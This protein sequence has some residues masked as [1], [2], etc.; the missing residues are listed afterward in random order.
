LIRICHVITDLNAGGAERMLVN[1]VTRLD[2]SRFDN[3]V[4]SLIEPGLMA[5]E[6]T[7]AGIPVMNL[8]MRRGRPSLSGMIALMRR[9]R[10]SRPAILQSW[11]YHADLAAALASWSIPDTSLVWNLRCSDLPNQSGTR[12]LDRIVR[13]L[14]WMSTRPQAVV[15]NSEKGKA[16]H[17]E[18]G[19]RPRRWA[20]IPNGVDT[21]RFRPSPEMR[22]EMRKKIGIAAGAPVIGWVARLHP[23]KDF[24][25]FL[26]AANLFSKVRQDA[27]FIL[28]GEGFDR[29]NGQ[30]LQMI[31]ELGLENH[32]SLLGVRA[33]MENIYPACDV[34]A[35][36]SA[37]GEG[38]PN[39]LIEAM[40]CGVPCV[41]TDVGDS[42]AIVADTGIIVPPRDP[43]ALMRGWNAVTAASRTEP[44]GDRARK[45]AVDQYSIDR[46]CL[47]YET[48]Y[49]ELFRRKQSADHGR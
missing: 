9:L 10:R 8:D 34:F 13:A 35:L 19:Y 2:R 11:L 18:F 37:Y 3:E 16:F 38:F 4:I 40:A 21:A 20:L 28:C 17:S 31:A 36:S 44:F 5:G 41:A 43:D 45:R 33:D 24:P 30:V 42:R 7:A 25:T 29:R 46:V 23:M 26:Q 15:V 49:Y 27:H 1:L 48:L 22:L 14:A 6:L 47:L 12:S 39:V 32:V